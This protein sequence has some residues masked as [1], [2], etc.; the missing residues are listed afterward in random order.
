[1]TRASELRDLTDDELEQ[2]TLD[3]LR[4]NLPTEPAD[5][6]WNI[7]HDVSRG[8]LEL[9]ERLLQHGGEPDPEL[10][11]E[12]VGGVVVPLVWAMRLL[13]SVTYSCFRQAF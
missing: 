11:G 12:P 7:I 3:V 8:P 2:I 1:M 6:D 5:V 13:L 4:R 9:P 10:G